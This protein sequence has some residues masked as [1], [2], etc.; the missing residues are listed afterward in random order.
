VCVEGPDVYLSGGR[1]KRGR[2]KERRP[3]IQFF[4]DPRQQDMSCSPI[5]RR[6]EKRK[7][8]KKEECGKR[9]DRAHIPHHGGH[10]SPARNLLILVEVYR[11][12]EMKEEDEKNLEI[13][14][15][16]KG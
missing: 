9:G 5:I 14:G 12:K 7:G 16:G 10:G 13:E 1:E 6:G 15:E 3:G 2:E 8:K 4:V 11:K